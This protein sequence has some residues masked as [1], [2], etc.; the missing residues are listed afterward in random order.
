MTGAAGTGTAGALSL[1]VGA[2]QSGENAGALVSAG[3]Q[4]GSVKIDSGSSAESESGAVKV[5]SAGG[6]QSVWRITS[7]G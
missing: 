2:G 7:Q 5:G 1:A 3:T 6:V 4:G